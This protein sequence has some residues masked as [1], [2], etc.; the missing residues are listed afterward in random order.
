VRRFQTQAGLEVDGLAG[1]RTL[2][3]LATAVDMPGL[4]KLTGKD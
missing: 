1:P 2:I 3:R 4:P